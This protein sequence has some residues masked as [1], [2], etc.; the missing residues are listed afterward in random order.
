MPQPSPLIVGPEVSS[1]VV[2][3]PFHA[4]KCPT[5]WL[6]ALFSH[7]QGCR[8]TEGFQRASLTRPTTCPSNYFSLDVGA[9]FFRLRLPNPS[10]GHGR[11]EMPYLASPDRGTGPRPMNNSCGRRWPS[12]PA[13]CLL[14]GQDRVPASGFRCLPLLVHGRR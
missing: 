8:A 14:V 7:G 13:L 2:V 3:R 1:L 9:M 4:Q 12:L 10:W 11:G 6:P 5:C